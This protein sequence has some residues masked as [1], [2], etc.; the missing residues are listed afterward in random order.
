VSVVVTRGGAELLR[1]DGPP[2][3]GDAASIAHVAPA[4]WSLNA[5]LPDGRLLAHAAGRAPPPGGRLHGRRV[6]LSRQEAVAALLRALAGHLARE[7]GLG[8]PG[9]P[10]PERGVVLHV[11]LALLVRLAGRHAPRALATPKGMQL[12]VMRALRP[13][14]GGPHA[15][16]LDGAGRVG[17]AVEAL[18]GAAPLSRPARD[19]ELRHAAAWVVALLLG[20]CADVLVP[21]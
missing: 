21:A 16:T 5:A 7:G 13:P 19:A 2:M 12:A 1:L 18:S 15:C 20:E 11:H 8:C 10:D 4:L 3:G 14:V 9:D 17:A 6:P